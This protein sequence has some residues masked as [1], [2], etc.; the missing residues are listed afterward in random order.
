[1]DIKKFRGPLLSDLRPYLN[2][3]TWGHDRIFGGHHPD[4][5]D[6]LL[7]PLCLVAKRKDQEL[8]A[9]EFVGLDGFHMN[10]Y[11]GKRMS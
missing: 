4:G 5:P 6:V 10:N 7:L 1:M 11:N 8:V 3:S 2:L 9:G